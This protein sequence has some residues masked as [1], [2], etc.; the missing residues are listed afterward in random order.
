MSYTNADGLFVLTDGDQGEVRG[1]G[2]TMK[3]ALKYLIFDIADATTIPTTAAAPQAND[4]FIPAGSFITNAYTVVT[5]AFTSGGSATLNIGLYE[6]DGTAIDADG[7]DA[8]IAVAALAA[9]DAVVNNGA[10][11]RGTATVGADN[12]YVAVDFN[13]AAFT[14]GAGKVVIEYIEV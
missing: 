12:A 10:L 6:Q 11:V 9:N 7:I 14:A 5:T 3:G 1:Q 8:A 13:T 4:P 2:E